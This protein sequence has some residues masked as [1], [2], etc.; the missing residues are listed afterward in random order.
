MNHDNACFWQQVALVAVVV[1]VVVVVVEKK[2]ISETRPMP[3]PLHTPKPPCRG[4][5]PVV[6]VADLSRRSLRH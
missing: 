4:S 1:V 5:K 2:K 6:S 3:F